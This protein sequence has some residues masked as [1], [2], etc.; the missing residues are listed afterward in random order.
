[1]QACQV[2]ASLKGGQ[3]YCAHGV[4]HQP[5]QARKHFAR[6]TLVLL[7]LAEHYLRHMQMAEDAQHTC[8]PD[9]VKMDQRA[10]IDQG[11]MD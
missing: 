2:V 8:A 5:R 6:N 10:S 11:G 7:G 4:P 9:L 3:L 1:M